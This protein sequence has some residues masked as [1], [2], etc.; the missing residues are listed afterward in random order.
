MARFVFTPA[1]QEPEPAPPAP[2]ASV[3]AIA[4]QLGT[5]PFSP[6]LT[7]SDT[8]SAY[9]WLI[10]GPVD[11]TGPNTASPTVTP[12]AGGVVTV[13]CLVTIGDVDVQA[14]PRTVLIGTGYQ[15]PINPQPYASTG[16]PTA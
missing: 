13:N 15:T 14:T 8:P 7:T 10:T 11:V 3:D 5:A 4:D 16:I 12:Y 2:T 9:F 6:T 1:A